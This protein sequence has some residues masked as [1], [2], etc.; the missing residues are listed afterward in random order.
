MQMFH[1]TIVFSSRNGWVFNN[2]W[3]FS[4]SLTKIEKIHLFSATSSRKKHFLFS[5]ENSPHY[6]GVGTKW[7]LKSLPALGH[8]VFLW[9]NE[10]YWWINSWSVLLADQISIWILKWS[11]SA[12][13]DNDT[14]WSQSRVFWDLPLGNW[15]GTRKELLEPEVKMLEEGLQHSSFQQKVF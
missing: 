13:T 9:F 15:N 3:T 2:A 1:V 8:S 14:Q 10:L 4:F 11:S 6:R 12:C 5:L 7:S